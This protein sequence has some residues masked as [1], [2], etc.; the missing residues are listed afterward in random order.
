ME[1]KAQ[2]SVGLLLIM[3]IAVIVGLVLFQA[4]AGNVGG[5]TTSASISN[6]LYTGPAAGSCIDLVGQELLS[7][8]T[9]T[10]RT[11]GATIP[12]TNYTITERVSASDGLKRIGYC[13]VG[14]Y[15]VGAVN[16]SYDYG[17]EG[18]IADGGARSI[19]GLIV[20]F[21]AIA[22]ALVVLAGIKFDW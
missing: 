14:A 20:L 11:D 1:K 7:A 16:I 17:P 3:A 21:G 18:Y 6:A 13:T 4:V 9:V 10:N 5:S 8:A 2:V 15:G 22:I 19:T 12:A